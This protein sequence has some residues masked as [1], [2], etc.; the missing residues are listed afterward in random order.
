[1]E[2]AECTTLRV[3]LNVSQQYMMLNLLTQHLLDD[4]Y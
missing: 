1:M 2:E 4:F 3:L